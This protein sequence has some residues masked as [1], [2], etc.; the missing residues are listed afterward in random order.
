MLNSFSCVCVRLKTIV[1]RILIVWKTIKKK[2]FYFE[3]L[4]CCFV[5]TY[6]LF[7]FLCSTVVDAMCQKSILNMFLQLSWLLFR[8]RPPTT[9][10]PMEHHHGDVT[11]FQVNLI[12][13]SK[14][15]L[16]IKDFQVWLFLER[17]PE[18]AANK[19]RRKHLLKK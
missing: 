12:L 14:R 15:S 5:G 17:L 6:Y 19:Y 3:S 13:G 11:D 1:V 10:W 2:L 4:F 16:T 8:S 7:V 9:L 18:V